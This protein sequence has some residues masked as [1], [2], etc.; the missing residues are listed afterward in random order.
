M[1]FLSDLQNIAQRISVLISSAESA[2]V[3]VRTFSAQLNQIMSLAN[4]TIQGS[5]YR[6]YQR[7]RSQKSTA[8]RVR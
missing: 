6:E 8:L 7:T 4:N 5:E 3:Q 2:T 1:A